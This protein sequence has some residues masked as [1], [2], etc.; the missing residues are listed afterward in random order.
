MKEIGSFH[1]P[2]GDTYMEYYEELE[3]KPT[4]K[5][6]QSEEVP[7]GIEVFLMKPSESDLTRLASSNHKLNFEKM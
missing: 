3:Y 7:N 2:D 5:K 6:E 4:L 1:N